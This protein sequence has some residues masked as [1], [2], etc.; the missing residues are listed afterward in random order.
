V[1][2]LATLLFAGL[3][4]GAEPA[5]VKP[6]AKPGTAD[7]TRK[8]VGDLLPAVPVLTDTE[9]L[10]IRTL[11]LRLARVEVLKAQLPAEEKAVT[12][13]LNKLVQAY[14]A[15]GCILKD[16]LTCEVKEVKKEK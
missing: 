13:E 1:R 9:K 6:V 11:Q 7:T 14:A 10:V 5:P 4:Y 15:K 12:E 8:A 3:L 2:L 16:D